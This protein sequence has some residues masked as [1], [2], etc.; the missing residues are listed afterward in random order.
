MIKFFELVSSFKS[1]IISL[2]Q[3]M[4]ILLKFSTFYTSKQTINKL[5]RR[6]YYTKLNFDQLE[7][8]SQASD[9]KKLRP[10][11]RQLTFAIHPLTY[12]GSIFPIRTKNEFNKYLLRFTDAYNSVSQP[13]SIQLWSNWR[14]DTDAVFRHLRRLYGCTVWGNC[15]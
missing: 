10:Q 14:T 15:W 7:N 3:K 5:H 11:R 4:P 2:Q 13:S 8:N 9:R 6:W 1:K 12:P